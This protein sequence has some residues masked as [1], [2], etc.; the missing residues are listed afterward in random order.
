MTRIYA[1]LLGLLLMAPA[2]SAQSSAAVDV[3]NRGDDL[4]VTVT[5]AKSLGKPSLKTTAEFL[6]LILKPAVLKPGGA[7][8]VAVDRGLIRKVEVRQPSADTVSVRI[9]VISK[10]KNDLQVA[11]GGKQ[12]KLKLSTMEIASA[13]P[14]AAP[15]PTR[16]TPA[17]PSGSTPPA[18][19]AGRPA[20]TSAAAK[21]AAA[22][23]RT[24]PGAA[25]AAAAAP[26]TGPAAAPATVEPGPAPAEPAA[27]PIQAEPAAPAASETRPAAPAPGSTPRSAVAQKTVSVTYQGGDLRGALQALAKAAG[28]QADIHPTVQGAVTA[29]FTEIPLNLAV[30]D[31]L[32]QSAELYLYEITDTQLKVYPHQGSSEPVATSA[33]STASSDQVARDYFPLRAQSAKE[34]ADAARKAVPSLT[35]RVDERLNIIIAEGSPEDLQRLRAILQ[36]VSEK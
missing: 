9:Y 29:S 19:P 28:L 21:P 12:V 27:S 14:A 15:K 23:P 25:P 8:N 1:M 32:G 10:P 24:S 13:G 31:L 2:A 22:S 35:Y 36:A 6:E 16:K 17:A 30:T 20:A 34:L 33:S 4:I 5:G 3:Q 26:R 18:T 7:R 11:A